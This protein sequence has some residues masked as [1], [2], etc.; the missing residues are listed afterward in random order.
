M[1]KILFLLFALVMLT[2]CEKNDEPNNRE[3]DTD[4][5]ITMHPAEGVKL[6]AGLI[7]D[8]ISGLTASEIVNRAYGFRY[9][10]SYLVENF[11][12]YKGHL[13]THYG[14]GHFDESLKNLETLS[15]KVIAKDISGDDEIS[16]ICLLYST[17]YI[18][19]ESRPV[20]AG[21][22]LLTHVQDPIAYIP[23][24]PIAAARE[25]ILSVFH[26]GNYA[27]VNRLLEEVFAF[28]PMQE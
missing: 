24:E 1:K 15:L 12:G 26:D 11:Q 3:L 8:T 17:D 23:N 22:T 19:Y 7:P 10:A 18:I 13:F 6:R 25:E 9:D 27:E 20:Y 5:I 16:L 14:E 2:S 21:E 4:I 28:L